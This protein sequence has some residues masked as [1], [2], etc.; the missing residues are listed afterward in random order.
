MSEPYTGE[1]RMFGGNFAPVKWAICMGQLL[2]ITNYQALYSLLGSAYGG[3]GRVSFG[4]PDMRGRIPVHAGNGPGLTPR[5]IGQLY[6]TESVQLEESTIPNHTH[7]IQV[8]DSAASA[9]TASNRV[10]ARQYMYEDPP[11]SIAQSP[12]AAGTIGNE[13]ENQAHENR[14]PFLSIQFIICLEGLYPQR[15]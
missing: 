10:L 12:L 6:G 13:G 9:T 1:I 3:D 4:L 8:S 2:N 7:S 14:M 15:S 11:G 5:S